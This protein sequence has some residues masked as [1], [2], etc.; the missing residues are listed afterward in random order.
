MNKQLVPARAV[1]IEQ[2]HRLSR[3]TYTRPRARR[4]DFHQRDQAVDLRLLGS[5]FGQYAPEPQRVFAERGTHPIVTGRRR[6][7]LIEDEVDNF[8]HRRQTGG[9]LGP[10]GHLEGD[11]LFG[12]GALSPDDALGDGGLRDEKRTRNLVSRQTSEQA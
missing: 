11:T 1:L 5:E 12:E 3:R 8:E 6:V 7:A 9:K 10:A 4:L 2:Q